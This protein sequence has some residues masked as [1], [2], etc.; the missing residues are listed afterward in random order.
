MGPGESAPCETTTQLS[1]VD[2]SGGRLWVYP[3]DVSG[4]YRGRRDRVSE[5]LLLVFLLLPW[6]RIGGQQA[7]L[8]DVAGGRI[9]LFGLRFWLH[10]APMLLFVAGGAAITLALVTSI[11]GRVWCGWAC[12]QTVFVDRVFRKIERWIE[13]DAVLRRRLDAA[14]W[15]TDKLAKKG[16][17]WALFTGVSLVISHSFLAYL[18]GTDG[19]ARAISEGPVRSPALFVAMLGMTG[20]IL[21][22]F[23][24]LREQFCTLLC[25]YGRF[26]SVLMDEQSR[27][28]TYDR[29]RKDCIDCRRCVNVCPT[30][31]DIRQGLQLECIACT[32][33]ID[34]CDAVMDKIRRPRGLV[35]F[36]PGRKDW[37]RP[38]GY[39]SALLVLIL[40]LASAIMRREPVDVALVRS[41]GSPYEEVIRAGVGREIV[42]RYRLD[43]TNQTF[44]RLTLSLEAGKAEAAFVASA[45]PLVLE[46]GA[47]R[48]VEV[49]VRF[50]F[51]VLKEGKGH[52]WIELRSGAQV[53]SKEVPLVGP[54]R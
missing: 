7:V 19:V 10:D 50:P 32:A 21:F 6:L 24:W 33:C 29:G 31:I 14:S 30:G 34:A 9:A 16:T 2:A 47:S 27:A 36:S 42:N 8:F 3:A 46:P 45:L 41:S 5:V 4:R 51:A 13:G 43:V 17:K 12:P 44:E 25:P 1:T 39:L 48:G 54:Y 18:L 22:D 28:V 38:A 11:W 53:I 52:T 49:F 20:F 37:S 23:G 35:G 26:Q 40:G 15:S